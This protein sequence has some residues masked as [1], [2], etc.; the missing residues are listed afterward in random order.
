VGLN[1]TEGNSQTVSMRTGATLES[2]T[3]YRELL[4]YLNYAR[5][6]ANSMETQHNAILKIDHSWLFAESPWTAFAKAGLA[7]DEF[8]PFDL[9]LNMSGGLGYRIL[10]TDSTTVTG[11]FGAGVSHEF[12]GPDDSWVPEAVFGFDVEHQLSKRQKFISKFDYYPD[13]TDFRDYRLE[14]DMGWELLI[15]EEANLSLKLS[16]IDRYDST[17]NGAK[18]ND[19]DY[20]LLLLWKL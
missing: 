14:L 6:S 9:R 18:N 15:D 1:G 4:I 5:T 12:G 8:K 17:P 10:D 2:K 11:R 20:A 7:Y 19:V 13:W 16:L 3:D